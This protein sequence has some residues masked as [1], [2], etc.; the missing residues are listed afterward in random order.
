MV[1]ASITKTLAYGATFIYASFAFG[2]FT[3]AFAFAAFVFPT[4]L[5]SVGSHCA[6]AGAT[7]PHAANKAIVSTPKNIRMFSPA[8]SALR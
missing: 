1:R 2:F 3:A 5:H 7:C 8:A 4:P 6:A